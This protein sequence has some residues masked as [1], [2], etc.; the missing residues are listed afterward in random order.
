[1][2]WWKRHAFKLREVPPP[3][4]W[5]PVLVF[6]STRKIVI[7]ARWERMAWRNW[8]DERWEGW[9]GGK[10]MHGVK[11]S[12]SGTALVPTVQ[13]NFCYSQCK[14]KD[15]LWMNYFQCTEKV[16][17]YPLDCKFTFKRLETFVTVT[18][19]QMGFMH[20]KNDRNQID[21]P[22]HFPI[23]RCSSILIFLVLF[24]FI[25]SQPKY[26]HNKLLTL[27]FSKYRGWKKSFLR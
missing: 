20:R 3:L 21:V 15:I 8:Y 10:G 1:M 5:F 12:W 7:R 13:R 9:N 11:H 25:N 4:Q 2:E 18:C 26:Q 19:I 27:A 23:S 22:W 17:G 24:P 16:D 6:L 14:H